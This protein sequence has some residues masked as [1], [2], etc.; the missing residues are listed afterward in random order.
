MC[1]TF[2]VYHYDEKYMSQQTVKGL[3][4]IARKRHGPLLYK[5]LN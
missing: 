2:E 1:S 3:I 5:L 4:N